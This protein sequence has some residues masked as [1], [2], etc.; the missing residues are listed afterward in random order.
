M[1]PIKPKGAD[2]MKCKKY[3][4]AYGSNMDIEAMKTRCP[5]A[6]I[7]GKAILEDWMLVFKRYAD[8]IP[9][10]GCEVPAL[11]WAI[12]D[13]EERKLDYYEG[14]PDYY[15][16]EEINVTMTSLRGTHPRGITALVYVMQDS[17]DIQP[18]AKLYYDCIHAAYERFGFDTKPIVLA[19]RDAINAEI[20]FY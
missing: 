12:T 9:R 4:L 13:S 10:I 6:S 17:H 3:Y 19:L 7:V 5:D 2:E 18:P 14:Y 20:G 15:T 8:I 11:I 1:N 16:K